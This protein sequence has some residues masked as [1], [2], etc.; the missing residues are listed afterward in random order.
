MLIPISPGL[1][2]PYY[3]SLASTLSPSAKSPGTSRILPSTS[4]ISLLSLSLTEMDH[5][6]STDDDGLTFEFSKES[7]GDMNASSSN[8]P[9]APA[10]RRNSLQQHYNQRRHQHYRATTP[11]RPHSKA[12][13]VASPPDSPG[14]DPISLCGSPT[15]LFLSTSLDKAMQGEHAMSLAGALASSAS[16]G[17]VKKRKKSRPSLLTVPKASGL[18]YSTHAVPDVHEEVEEDDDG[19]VPDSPDLQPVKS[20]KFDAPMTPLVLESESWLDAKSVE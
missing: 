20:P 19:E 11:S 13:S 4:A 14:L 10:S 5:H 6:N 8:T 3:Q 15:V 18:A 16:S 7:F 17:G 1:R 12:A 2:Y 9:S